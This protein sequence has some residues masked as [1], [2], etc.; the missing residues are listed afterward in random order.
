M[1]NAQEQAARLRVARRLGQLIGFSVVAAIIVV[2]W[3]LK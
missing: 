3:S 2:I 1:T